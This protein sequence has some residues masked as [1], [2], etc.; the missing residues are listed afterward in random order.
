MTKPR[1]EDQIDFDQAIVFLQERYGWTE[2]HARSELHRIVRAGKVWICE[3]YG[4]ERRD[5]QFLDLLQRHRKL[6]DDTGNPMS[7]SIEDL[8]PGIA[9]KKVQER[10]LFD[11]A[12]SVP[13]IRGEIDREYFLWKAE[14]EEAFPG[15]S[16]EARARNEEELI[17]R[18]LNDEADSGRLPVKS[19]GYTQGELENN[20]TDHGPAVSGR[21]RTRG[22]QLFWQD[23]DGKPH[24]WRARAPG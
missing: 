22:V 15:P 24:K 19:K 16:Q 6:A 3:K 8:H 4:H 20:C 11:A 13:G 7:F 10:R 5:L 18:F 12:L 2:E 14:L 21:S 1:D 9:A 17:R 23:R